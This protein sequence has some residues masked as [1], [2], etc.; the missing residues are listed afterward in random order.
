MFR[1]FTHVMELYLIED[2]RDSFPGKSGSELT[3]MLI[4]ESLYQYGFDG[5]DDKTPAILRTEKGKPYTDVSKDG[6]QVHFSVSHS[7]SCF[8]CIFSRQPVGIDIQQVRHANIDKL[9]RRY[10]TQEEQ[11]YVREHGSDGFFRLWTRKEAYAKLTGLG[12]E[13]IMRKTSV[14]DRKD[15]DFSD[16]RLSDDMYCSCCTMAEGD[17]NE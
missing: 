2:Y 6:R 14:L 8:A 4:T 12:I 5:S 1:H 17:E 7:G 13:E 16:F 11:E 10:F 15:V 3:D 9:S